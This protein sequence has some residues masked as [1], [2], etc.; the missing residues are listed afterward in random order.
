V[1]NIYAATVYSVLIRDV[2]HIWVLNSLE[3]DSLLEE[4]HLKLLIEKRMG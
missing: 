3:D 4:M 2:R 1:S